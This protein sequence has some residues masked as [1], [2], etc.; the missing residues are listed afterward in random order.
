MH[1]SG[2]YLTQ[3]FQHPT[4]LPFIHIIQRKTKGRLQQGGFVID[5]NTGQLQFMELEVKAVENVN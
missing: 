2:I 4:A 1:G 5:R 3:L